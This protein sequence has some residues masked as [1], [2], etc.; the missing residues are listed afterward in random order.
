MLEPHSQVLTKVLVL[1]WFGHNTYL[2]ILGYVGHIQI[3]LRLAA[4]GPLDIELVEQH[5]NLTR[6]GCKCPFAVLILW[7]VAWV[8]EI[9]S[10]EYFLLFNSIK[11]S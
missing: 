1:V 11:D 8:T 6:C 5:L 9:I 7:V 4:A 10:Y 3:V 2:G